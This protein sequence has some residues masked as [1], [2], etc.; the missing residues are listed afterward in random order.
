MKKTIEFRKERIKNLAIQAAIDHYNN[1]PMTNTNVYVLFSDS[2]D[3][4]VVEWL[5]N[6]NVSSVCMEITSPD[7][8]D[9]KCFTGRVGIE[10]I[11]YMRKSKE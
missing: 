3:S 5:S 4:R 10:A 1:T 7:K 9:E 2:L 6:F 11:G 8:Y